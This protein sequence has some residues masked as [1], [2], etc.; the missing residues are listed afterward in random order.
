MVGGFCCCSCNTCDRLDRRLPA[1]SENLHKAAVVSFPALVYLFVWVG[2]FTQV[3]TGLGRVPS[4]KHTRGGS[5]PSTSPAP[6]KKQ[7]TNSS[8]EPKQSH[9]GSP[10]HAHTPLAEHFPLWGPSHPPQAPI[11]MIIHANT[12]SRIL[13]HTKP[14][15]EEVYVYIYIQLYTYTYIRPAPLIYIYT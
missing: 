14:G 5:R 9:H 4:S 7:K 13:S 1:S 8:G 12:H 3:P 6:N 11:Y 2:A 10:L 15:A